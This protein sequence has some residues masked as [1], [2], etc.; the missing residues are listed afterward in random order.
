MIHAPD[1][2]LLFPAYCS[3][4]VT[5]V[6]KDRW[7]HRHR[8]STKIGHV[9][10]RFHRASALRVSSGGLAQVLVAS[11]QCYREAERAHV[12]RRSQT[13]H[14]DCSS[15]RR[16]RLP[17]EQLCDTDGFTKPDRPHII[18]ATAR[19]G[20]ATINTAQLPE[21][22]VFEVLVQFPRLAVAFDFL[23]ACRREADRLPVG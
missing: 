13:R 18:V 19:L 5:C 17:H 3:I 10:P 23:T 2:L 22:T 6:R 1:T 9:T 8:S 16:P 7:S 14:H 20:R 11:C 4:L 15:P 21:A 12:L